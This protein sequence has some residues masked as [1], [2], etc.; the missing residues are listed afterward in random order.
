MHR[1][2]LPAILSCPPLDFADLPKDEVGEEL[3]T[4]MER[5]Q[6]GP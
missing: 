3:L 5:Y 4:A 6:G 2:V 1:D